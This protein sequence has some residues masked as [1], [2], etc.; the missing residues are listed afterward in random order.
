MISKRSKSFNKNFEILPNEAKNLAVKS[1][2]L[3]KSNHLH[4]SLE[5]KKISESIRSIR[6]GDHYR[7]LAQV[8]NDVITWFWIGT[9]EE[10]NNL[11]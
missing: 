10:Y 4:P 8:K 6:I 5:Y 1:Y 2:K 3:W 9:H 11:T 7:A